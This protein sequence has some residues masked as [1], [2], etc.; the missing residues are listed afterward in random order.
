MDGS[1]IHDIDA[2]T[3]AKAQLQSW[4]ARFG[5]PLRITIDQGRQFES[6]SVAELTRLIRADGLRTTSYHRKP[7]G[8]IKRQHRQL[9]AAINFFAL[10]L[11]NRFIKEEGRNLPFRH[12]L[13][14]FE[15]YYDGRGTNAA[16]SAR[17]AERSRGRNCIHDDR[18]PEMLLADA[19]FEEIQ[20]VYRFRHS[21]WRPVH[22]VERPSVW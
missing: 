1:H 2:E 16:N 18:S 12:R 13:P 11:A 19:T 17:D 7:N 6:C 8:M 5:I 9:E 14:Q 4:I 22:S 15:Q 3:V 10:Q 21:R 20:A